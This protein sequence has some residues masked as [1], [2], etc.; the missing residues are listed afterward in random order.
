TEEAPQIQQLLI[1]LGIIGMIFGSFTA[2][3]TYNGKRVL[4]YSTI[5]QVGFI[6]VAIG[7]GTPLALA[8]AI[9]YTFNHAFIKSALLMMMGLVAS[10]NHEHSVDFADIEGTGHALPPLIG[11]LWFVGGM[12]L[13]GV[14][15]MNGFISKVAIVQSGVAVAQWLPLGLAIASGALTLLYMFSTW[16]RVFQHKAPLAPDPSPTQAGRGEKNKGKALVLKQKVGLHGDGMLAPTFLIA[17]CVLLGLYARPLVILAQQ[18]ALQ[19]SNPSLYIDAVR[20]FTGG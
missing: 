11:A 8:A 9:I 18:T 12:A 10:R 2:L 13:A 3:R 4:A 16:Q 5:G 17:I 19:I 20:L 1:V 15:P 14:P 7:W 6:L